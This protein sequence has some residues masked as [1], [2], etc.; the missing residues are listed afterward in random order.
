MSKKPAKKDTEPDPRKLDE[1]W[2]KNRVASQSAP[3]LNRKPGKKKRVLKKV[4]GK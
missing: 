1:F 3:K 2:G 4:V